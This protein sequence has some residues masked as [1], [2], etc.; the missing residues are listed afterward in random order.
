MYPI[1]TGMALEHLPAPHG[2]DQHERGAH[3]QQH[4]DGRAGGLHDGLVA[5]GVRDNH[6][7]PLLCSRGH[8]L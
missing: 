4:H 8:Q 7:W 3:E 6:A 5:V 1:S 2:H